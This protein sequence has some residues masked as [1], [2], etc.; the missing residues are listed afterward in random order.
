MYT[1]I[2]AG[3][4]T[5]PLL[6]NASTP[7]RF[8]QAFGIDLISLIM[9]SVKNPL[10]DGESTDIAVR[11]AYVMSHQAEKTDLDKLSEEHFY[12]WLEN[13]DVI[14]L[15]SVNT[16]ISIWQAYTGQTQGD[17]KAKKKNVKQSEK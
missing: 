9:G 8:K 4:K 11:L 3:E 7:Y 15:E 5:I 2:N 16:A 14:E 6:S 13:Y 1:E 12:E 17:S 10:S